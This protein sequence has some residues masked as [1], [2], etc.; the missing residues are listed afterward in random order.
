MTGVEDKNRIVQ[1][2]WV[3][4]RLSVME[5]LS[6][7]SF[8]ANGHEYH[9]YAYEDVEGVPPGAVLKDANAILDRSR[10]FTYRSG[11]GKDS[12]AGFA[13]FFRHQLLLTNGGWWVDSDVICVKHLDL[14][15]DQ[16][17]ASSNEINYGVV[18]INCAMRTPA[19][20]V[21][22][23]RLTE[24][25]QRLDPETLQFGQS[26]PLLLQRIV[27]EEKLEGD[28]VPPEVFC[29]IGWRDVHRIVYSGRSF[30]V[31]E[32]LRVLKRRVRSL[33]RPDLKI[34]T[35]TEATRAVHLWNEVWRSSGIDKN[36]T[37][38]PSCLYEKLKRRYL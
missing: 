10:I 3:G 31:K 13:N 30:S 17:L 21:L 14:A 23:R 38:A 29:P 9:L 35:I 27:A 24:E 5:Q 26:G 28:I 6:I 1:G 4:P 22:A 33:V 18:A 25:C 36:Q 37:F 12:Y 19:N 16:V 20:S 2:L 15:A 32:S 34:G 11:Y 7:R 8:L